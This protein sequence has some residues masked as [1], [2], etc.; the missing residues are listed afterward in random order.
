MKLKGPERAWFSAA[1]APS[2]SLLEELL[3]FVFRLSF[4]QPGRT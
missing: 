1:R 4:E 3:R 2:F